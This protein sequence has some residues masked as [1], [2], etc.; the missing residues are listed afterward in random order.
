M[1]RLF[2]SQHCAGNVICDQVKAVGST[3]RRFG[4]WTNRRSI[5]LH[6]QV[7]RHAKL[8]PGKLDVDGAAAWHGV[9]E[10]LE[11]LQGLVCV[12][13]V[14]S[15]HVERRLMSQ[16]LVGAL[17]R[18]RV[19]ADGGLGNVTSVVHAQRHS[20]KGGPDDREVAAGG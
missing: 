1:V 6:V 15:A 3:A 4:G 13:G 2:R 5:A 11:L 20:C 17:P 16:V 18:L 14:A 19:K 12:A 9:A 8:G 10:E 7:V